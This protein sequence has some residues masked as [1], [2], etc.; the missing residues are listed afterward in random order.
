M[1]K[2]GLIF[3]VTLMF[4]ATSC[5]QEKASSPKEALEGTPAAQ[6]QK[7]EPV[8]LPKTTKVILLISEQNIESPQ[9][10]WWASQ[11]DLSTTEAGIARKLIEGGYEILD[12]SSLSG[13]IKQK[14]AFQVIELGESESISLGTASGA[15]Y[16]VLGKAVASAGGNVPQSNMRSCFANVTAK[17][18]HVPDG[19]VVQYLEASGNSIH[20]DVITGGRE[21]LAKAASNLALQITDALNK[22]KAGGN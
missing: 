10:A 14:P 8:P 17:L 22:E 13:I 21:A 9:R 4:F 6:S 1:N 15:D 7:Q 5:A 12:P 16:V 2:L 3:L 18:I 11:I 20:T 19:K